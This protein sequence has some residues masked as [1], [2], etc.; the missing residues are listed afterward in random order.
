MGQL[1]QFHDHQNINASCSVAIRESIVSNSRLVDTIFAYCVLYITILTPY[2]AVRCCFQQIDCA[3]LAL[4]KEGDMMPS[5]WELVGSLQNCSNLNKPM[6]SLM[7]SMVILAM[8]S[9]GTS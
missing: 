4:L 1:S 8:A 5:C 7:L 6:V 9:P 2:S 3:H